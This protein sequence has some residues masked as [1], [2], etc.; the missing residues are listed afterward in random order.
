M[1]CGEGDR[2]SDILFQ[3]ISGVSGSINT[4][5]RIDSQLDVWNKVAYNELVKDPHR[6]AE[7]G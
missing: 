1:E 3:C 7:E 5:D 4:C 2:F 6:A